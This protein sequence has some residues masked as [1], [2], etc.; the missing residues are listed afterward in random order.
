[1]GLIVILEKCILKF[2]ENVNNVCDDRTKTA[3]LRVSKRGK[4]VQCCKNV[5]V[6][7]NNKVIRVRDAKSLILVSRPNDKKKLK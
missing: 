3:F 7:G 4:S 1:M 6:R 2:V 5:S